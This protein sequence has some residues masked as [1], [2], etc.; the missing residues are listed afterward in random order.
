MDGGLPA[1]ADFRRAMKDEVQI[2]SQPFEI[3][4]KFK[5]FPIHLLRREN[6]FFALPLKFPLQSGPSGR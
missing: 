4:N 1:A 3:N 2:L 5:L 6:L